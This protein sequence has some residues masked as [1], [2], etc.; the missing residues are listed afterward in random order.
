MTETPKTIQIGQI[1]IEQGVLT[2]QQVFE[3]VQAQKQCHQPFGLL[4]E[5]MFDVTIGSIEEAWVE[6]YHRFTGTIDLERETIDDDALRLINRRQAHQFEIM[7]IRFEP[8]GELLMAASKLRLARAVAF[9]AT[10]IDHVTFFR[11]AEREPLQNFLQE[12]YPLPGVSDEI[13][14]QAKR[15]A[16]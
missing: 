1:L 15:M 16:G 2:E 7:P 14:E 10:K 11:V 3:I 12:H 5:Q 4:A 9:V 13:I 6:Q 8:S